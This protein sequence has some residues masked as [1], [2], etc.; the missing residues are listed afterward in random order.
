[1]DLQELF[2]WIGPGYRKRLL[3]FAKDHILDRKKYP[4]FSETYPGRG[5]ALY[6]CFL[7]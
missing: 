4:K 3:H 6:E 1:M 2:M 7:V 5:S